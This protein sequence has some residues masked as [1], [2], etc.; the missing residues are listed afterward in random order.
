MNYRFRDRDKTKELGNPS[1]TGTRIPVRAYYH[2]GGVY[3]F[4][5]TRSIELTRK[6]NDVVYINNKI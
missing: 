2:G 3:D 1:I 4:G 5:K 6:F